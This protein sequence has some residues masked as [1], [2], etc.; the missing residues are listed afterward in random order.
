MGTEFPGKVD[1]PRTSQR[2]C[3]CPISES[4]HRGRLSVP[5]H[6]G[7]SGPS[8]HSSQPPGQLNKRRQEHTSSL[9]LRLQALH[10]HPGGT[11]LPAD[12]RGASRGIRHQ[13]LNSTLAVLFLSGRN[14]NDVLGRGC[15][16]PAHSHLRPSAS[17]GPPCT[18]R[19]AHSGIPSPMVRQVA[20]RQDWWG[21]AHSRK[22]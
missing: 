9:V 11:G 12:S 14:H 20:S 4:E 5:G 1:E 18:R 7:D 10:R 8:C 2:N 15:R 13:E 19:E 16:S 17:W 3:L 21:K 22:L 6:G